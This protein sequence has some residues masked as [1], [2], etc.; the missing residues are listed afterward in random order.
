M[1]KT[2]LRSLLGLAAVAVVVLVAEPLFAQRGG[3]RGAGRMRSYPKARLATLN[4]VQTDLKLTDEQKTKIA[5]IAD[6]LQNDVRDLFT[7]GGP[8]DF[9]KLEKLNQDASAKVDEVLEADQQK[10]LTGITIQVNG[11]AALNDPAIREQLKFSEEQ[12]AKFKEAQQAN[13]QAGREFFNSF[14]DMSPEERQ[15]KRDE[16]IQAADKRLMAVL[17]AE[18]QT[19]F[20]ALKG[21]PLPVD[22]AP[23]M[24]RGFGG[25]RQRGN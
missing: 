8:P 14:R 3:G 15:T 22:L 21:E 13:Q 7:S 23:L 2:L 25:G 6:Q 19:A 11:A 16:L 4:E 10:R 20:E 18:Q 24:P 17:T 1:N 9:E 12:N 5:E